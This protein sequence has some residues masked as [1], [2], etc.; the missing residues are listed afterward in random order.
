MPE[1]II[2]NLDSIQ[3]GTTIWVAKVNDYNWNVYRADSIPSAIIS[4]SDNLNGRARVQFR[5]QHGLSTG[6]N[7]I[8]KFFDPAVDGVYRV[9]SVSSLTSVEIDYVFVGNVTTLIGDG[10]GFILQSASVAQPSDIVNLSYAKQLESGAKVWVDDNGDGR[11]TVLEKTDPFREITSIVPLTPTI[12]QKF[13][14]AV[15]Q[16]F[17]NLSALVGAPGYDSGIGGIYTYVRE[18]NDRYVQDSDLPLLLNAADVAGF[19][20]AIE[21]GDQSWAV[22][23][24]SQSYN[25]EGYALTTFR[26]E[27]SNAFESR[28]LLLPPDEDFGN[29]EFG[30]AVTISQDERW[31]YIGAPGRNKVYAFGR[32]DMQSQQVVYITTSGVISYNF[33]D[34]LGHALTDEQLLVSLDNNILRLNPGN[35]PNASAQGDYYV[36]SGNIILNNSPS[37]GQVLVIARRMRQRRAARLRPRAPAPLPPVRARAPAARGQAAGGAHRVCQRR[38]LPRHRTTVRPR[39]VIARGR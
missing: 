25:G 39:P 13:G 30:S 28:Q 11:W 17:R 37:T 27:N 21:I 1:N 23:G 2:N 18:S 29:A 19:G 12:N 31:M 15:A 32:V 6:D 20:N 5:G 16:G 10:P 14:S 35:D 38:P 24:A 3:V 34:V 26:A 22:A 9:R 4:V 7:L 36:L 33:S 8:I